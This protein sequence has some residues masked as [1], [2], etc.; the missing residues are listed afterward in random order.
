MEKSSKSD[1]KTIQLIQE[2]AQQLRSNELA[3]YDAILNAIGD[4]QIVMIGEASHGIF[5]N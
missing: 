2:N 4:A 3:D 5:N 1:P